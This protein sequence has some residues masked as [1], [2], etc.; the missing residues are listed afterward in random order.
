[1]DARRVTFNETVDIRFIPMEER[2][3]P[4]I[5]NRY[6]FE[7]RCDQLKSLLDPIIICHLTQYF[8]QN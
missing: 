7:R 5:S 4:W 6:W 3:G 2:R 1:M 8:K